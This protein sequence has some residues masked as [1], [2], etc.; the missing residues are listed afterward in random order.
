MRI[1]FLGTGAAEGIPAFRCL[2]GSCRESRVKGGRNHRQNASVYIEGDNSEHILIDCPLQIKARI[3][4]YMIDESRITD[5]FI[6]HF[7]EDHVTGLY[8]LAESRE[9]NGFI[10]DNRI[11]IHMPEN[12]LD[13]VLSLFDDESLC[14]IKAITVSEMIRVGE[15]EIIPLET[16]HLNRIPGEKNESFGYLIKSGLKSIAYLVD[17]SRN[18]PEST[19]N[20][21]LNERINYLVYD[22]TFSDNPESLGHSDI[23]G[24]VALKKLVRP[25]HMI[26][27][28]ISHRNYIHDELSEIMKRDGIETA[29][30][31]MEITLN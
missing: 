10:I 6:T 26:I 4:D 30:D 24:A 8:Y 19:V 21:L 27:T 18:L 13:K 14:D 9:S 23:K 20:K 1:V 17:A 15:I 22:C 16:N 3:N 7:H 28:H 2:C 5:L 11:K 29:W 12:C 31:G 25:D